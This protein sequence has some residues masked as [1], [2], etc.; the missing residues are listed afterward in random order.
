MSR[1]S[2]DDNVARVKKRQA[3]NST[4]GR[5]GFCGKEAGRL[6]VTAREGDGLTTSDNDVAAAAGGSQEAS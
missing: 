3:K 2:L 6:V 4:R 1:C 5:A